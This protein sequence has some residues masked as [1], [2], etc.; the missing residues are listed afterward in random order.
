MLVTVMLEIEAKELH[1]RLAKASWPTCIPWFGAAYELTRPPRLYVT[2]L[3]GM[4]YIVEGK[5][6]ATTADMPLGWRAR[7]VHRYQV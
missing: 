2:G 3:L 6:L 5:A 7:P 1:R 4:A